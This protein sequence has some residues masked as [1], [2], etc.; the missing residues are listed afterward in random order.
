MKDASDILNRL[1]MIHDEAS[2][3]MLREASDITVQAFME[4]A[5]AVREEID[6]AAD[7]GN[8]QLHV[9]V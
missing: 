2:I 4:S 8:R 5:K 7:R 9:R 6:D 3:A 1:R